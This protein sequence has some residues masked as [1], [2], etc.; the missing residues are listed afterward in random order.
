MES[1]GD[2]LKPW[3]IFRCLSPVTNVCVKR[4]KKRSDAD[5]Y[6]KILRQTINDPL[7]V[8]F[9]KQ[10]ISRNGVLD[11]SCKEHFSN[12]LTCY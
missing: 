5:E 1:Y 11:L 6:L 10:K 3:A 8:V 9:D 12:T 4:F 2:T 7:T